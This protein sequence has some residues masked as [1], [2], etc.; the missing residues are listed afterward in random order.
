MNICSYLITLFDIT[1]SRVSSNQSATTRQRTLPDL[2]GEYSQYTT[3]RAW[4]AS[5]KSG[6]KTRVHQAWV[7]GPWSGT[8]QHL[9]ESLLSSMRVTPIIDMFCFT[10]FSADSICI[11]WGPLNLVCFIQI[12]KS[13]TLN[14]HVSQ[15]INETRLPC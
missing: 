8:H 11:V 6:N 9:D 12:F 1:Y 10:K 2:V 13:R 4:K 3:I 5:L 7:Q 15:S 14:E